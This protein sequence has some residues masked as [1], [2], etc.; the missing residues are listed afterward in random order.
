MNLANP[1][2]EKI[3]DKKCFLRYNYSDYNVSTAENA[4]M[5]VFRGFEKKYLTKH[6]NSGRISN[7]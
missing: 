5:R 3:F 6:R 4:D 7:R 1:T 2:S